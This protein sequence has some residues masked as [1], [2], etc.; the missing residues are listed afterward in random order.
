MQWDD[1]TREEQDAL[2]AVCSGSYS[3]ITL[4]SLFDLKGMGLVEAAIG[5]PY[6]TEAGRILYQTRASSL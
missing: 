4:R 6:P 1:L 3:R 5:R 2:E